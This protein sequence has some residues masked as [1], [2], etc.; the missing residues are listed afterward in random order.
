MYYRFRGVMSLERVEKEDRGRG[1]KKKEAHRE[2]GERQRRLTESSKSRFVHRV[3][4]IGGGV[5]VHDGKKSSREKF[6]R[7]KGE[8]EWTTV[9]T[10]DKWYL[11]WRPTALLRPLFSIFLSL[12]LT[13]P[14]PALRNREKRRE[15]MRVARSERRRREGEKK[16][17]V[18]KV[19]ERATPHAGLYLKRPSKSV[20]GRVHEVH[21]S[22]SCTCTH[23]SARGTHVRLD[24]CG[25]R[26]LQSAA[27]R[28]SMH[29]LLGQSGFDRF[30]CFRSWPLHFA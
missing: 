5:C 29:F 9:T 18:Q 21:T 6:L 10:M 7:L 11:L 14:R 26:S 2:H 19:G 3:K 30:S 25:C 24:L 27:A 4:F 15:G 28:R 23:T 20:L 13:R 17:S 1:K 22:T 16:V 8:R 12:F